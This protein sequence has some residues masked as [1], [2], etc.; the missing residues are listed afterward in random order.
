MKNYE[1]ITGKGILI[2]K[3]S[4]EQLKNKE[5]KELFKKVSKETGYEYANTEIKKD[6]MLVYACSLEDCRD[7]A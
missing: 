3:F 7:F 5:D 2:G 4:E 1:Y 6:K